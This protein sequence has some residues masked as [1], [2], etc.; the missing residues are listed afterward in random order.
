[1]RQ[2]LLAIAILWSCL[3]AAADDEIVTT[4]SRGSA[5]LG[6]AYQKDKEAFVGQE[7]VTGDKEFVGASNSSFSLTQS[8]TESQ[9]ADD[10][11]FSA[12]GRGRFGVVEASASADFFSKSVS[13]SF[14]TSSI[15][16]ATYNFRAQKLKLKTPTLLTDIG[17]AVKN[18]D[19]RWNA[20]CGN[21]YVAEILSGAKLFF[22]IVV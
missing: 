19:D 20:T 6:G 12:G 7:C 15:Y 3:A 10:L 8:M 16:S 2:F 11:G 5:A 21:G 4:M 9:L 18:N 17:A 1:M 22:S 14:S 13:N